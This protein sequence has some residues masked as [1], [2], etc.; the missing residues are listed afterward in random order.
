MRENCIYGKPAAAVCINFIS[1]SNGP[2]VFLSRAA[3]ELGR[4]KTSGL[5]KRRPG[6][7]EGEALPSDLAS[8]AKSTGLRPLRERQVK[9][10]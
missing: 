3:F 10:R 7:S 2:F 4:G 9:T 6:H 5:Y 1:G 8:R